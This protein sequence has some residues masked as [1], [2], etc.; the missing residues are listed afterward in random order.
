MKTA[1]D[2]SVL[3]ILLR[4]EVGWEAWKEKLSRT[5]TEGP[6]LMCPVVFS[7]CSTGFS[8]L[9]QA[10]QQFESLQIR[11]DPISPE[12]AW[13]AGQIFL[14]YK[15]HHGARDHLLP[16][17]LVAAHASIQADR[18]AAVDRGYLRSYFPK[19]KVLLA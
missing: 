3:L 17:F 9:E 13:L 8:S 11:Y 2:S 14:R 15:K 5:A 1:L 19:L 12:S 10:R 16:D 6:L 18:L 7:E 4:R